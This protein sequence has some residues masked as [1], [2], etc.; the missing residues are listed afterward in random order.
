MIGGRVVSKTSQSRFMGPDGTKDI[1][2]K[3]YQG[4]SFNHL[5]VVVHGKSVVF[6]S[7]Y[8]QVCSKVGNRR[9]RSLGLGWM[10]SGGEEVE[11]RVE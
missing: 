7:R 10:S 8:I 9:A 5:E 1:Q 2:H 4:S 6:E 3:G 11:M